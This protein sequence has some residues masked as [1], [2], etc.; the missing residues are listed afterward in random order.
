MEDIEE[1]TRKRNSEII[2]SSAARRNIDNHIKLAETILHLFKAKEK[3]TLYWSDVHE[4]LKTS[5]L[6]TFVDEKEYR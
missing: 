3:S 5:N 6:N 4:S 2:S 1:E